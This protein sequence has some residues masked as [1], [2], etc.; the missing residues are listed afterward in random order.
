[1]PRVSAVHCMAV[2]I[3]SKRSSHGSLETMGAGYSRRVSAPRS[4][5]G[6]R[7][8]VGGGIGSGKTTVAEIMGRLGAA[9][10]VADEVGHEV[11]EPGGA[12][13]DMVAATWPQVVVEGRID[14]KAL[15]AIVFADGEELDR[16]EAITH[17]AI[18]ERIGA[19]VRGA[20]GDV[21]LETPVPTMAG[22][23]GPWV[24]VFVDAPADVRFRRAVGRGGDP[25]DMMRRMSSQLERE[26][27][28]RWADRVIVND[29]SVD[30][31]EA[32]VERLWTA[33]RAGNRR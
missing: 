17:P 7:V 30:A 29:A 3:Q 2:R 25:D 31:L 19:I 27:W 33:L 8:V 23:D 12:A 6:L 16:L 28:L 26:Q 21:V 13:H 15:A 22:G 32:E 14:R 20:V 11:L 24:K 9:V 10:V 5:R 18:A 1:M 4:S